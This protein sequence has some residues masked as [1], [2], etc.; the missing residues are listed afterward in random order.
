MATTAS[1]TASMRTRKA[2]SSSNYKSS[3][4]S[5]EYYE[6]SY[7]F[8]GIVHFAGMNLTNKV[9]TGISL[10]VSSA[11]AGYGAG[12]TKTVYVRK[13]RYQ[14]ASQ[15]GVTGGNYYGD[16]LGTFTGSFYGNTT[17]YTFSGD[18]LTNMAAYFEAGNNTICL[19][20]PSPTKS[21]QGYSTN[22][23]QWESAT[24][25]ITYEEGVSSPSLSAASIYMGN[26][27]T[28]YTNRL[29]TASTH[30]I[31]YSFGSASGTI[32]TGVGDSASW[33]PPASLAA[34]IP[35]ATSGV[36]AIT[37]AT[38]Y[39]GVWTG[40]KTIYLTLHV[41]TNMLPSIT[42]VSIGEAV[43]GLSAQFG[44]YVQGKSRLSVS[45]SA[46]GA[47]G[48]T[49][50]SYRT[51][52]MG[53][54]YSGSSFTTGYLGTAGN[55]TMTITAT[56]SRGRSASVTRTIAVTAYSAPV[57]AS[58]SAARCNAGGTA[59]QTDGTRA[60]ITL[61]AT[62][63]GVGSK[64]TMS[65]SIYYKLKTA[66]AWTLATTIAHTSY[67]I[68]R[69]NFA[70][71]ASI[72][73]DTLNGYDLRATVSDYFT[74]I[75]STTGLGTKEV[76]LDILASGTGIAFGKVANIANAVEVAD[77]MAFYAGGRNLANL[78]AA[79]LG[80][81]PLSGGTL[82]G[83]LTIQGSLYPSMYLQPTYNNTTNRIVFEGSYAGA[84]SFSA[85][86]DSTGNN[87][88]MLE[89]RNAAYEAS[90][91]NALVL[92]NVVNG[93]YYTYRVF[94]AGMAT[95]VPIANGGTAA[96]SAKAAL[97]NLGIFYSAS[98]PASGTDGQI[99]LVPA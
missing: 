23:L 33:T 60:W 77:D 5:Q 57:I 35:S 52:L 46:S 2:S 66:T 39:S 84:A 80:A 83:N 26:A 47:Q 19:F 4:A 90:L 94:H 61:A 30:T 22:Y 32:A 17:N 12:H 15:S 74:S 69:T 10:R 78:S 31:T 41:P 21:S 95:P 44:A 87:R 20:N 55:S 63:S 97:N 93:S 9:I 65:C 11:Q 29:S 45:I 36:C 75:S 56:D 16:A 54:T 58:F 64:N 91:N 68:S 48:S 28:I 1:Y 99:C 96:S 40:S 34:Q 13:S 37:C 24:I 79:T 6:N 8:V 51:T 62:A 67:A 85:W 14:A 27:V 38:Y 98:L 53:S 88:R 81:L 7:N 50:S 49:I 42:S 3:A 73:F 86:Q 25:T 89:V 70:L 59:I 18:L 43:S 82:T 92:R 76:I 72:S 71:P